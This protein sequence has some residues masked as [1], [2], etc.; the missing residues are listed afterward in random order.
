MNKPIK[1][2]IS[3]SIFPNNIEETKGIYIFHQARALSKICSVKIVAPIP[4]FPKYIKLGSYQHYNKI[5][6][7]QKIHGLEVFHPRVP[8]IPKFGRCLY[9]FLYY[10]GQRSFYKK[11]IPKYKPDVFL[12]FWAY[13]DGFANVMFARNFHIPHFLGGRGCD[14]NNANNDMLKRNM[15]TWALNKSCKVLSVSKAM[16]DTMISLGVPSKKI[17]V[18][19]NGLNDNFVSIKRTPLEAKRGDNSKTI[20]YCGRFSQEKGVEYLIK[21][22]NILRLRKVNFKLL[23]IGSGPLKKV[24]EEMINELFLEDFIEIRNE[25]AHDQIPQIMESA[26]IFCLPSLREGWPNVVME[27]LACGLPVVAS[28]V[29]GVPEIITNDE[30]GLLT[31][32]GDAGGLAD[33]L[34]NA[35]KK[36]WNIE[37]LQLSV[38]KRTWNIVAKEIYSEIQTVL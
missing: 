30:Y 20:L 18:I 27:A 36:R 14:I 22:C 17:A 11:F 33:N 21:A 9:G 31:S 26:D 28:T 16:K 3:S 38:K 4:Y 15:T 1:V 25:V 7:Q 5:P 32:P 34:E 12:S 37:K 6:I 8:V 2:L 24:F 35:L 29:G 13:P 19:P 10:L 23:M